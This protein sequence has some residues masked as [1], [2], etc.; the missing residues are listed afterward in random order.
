RADAWGATESCRVLVRAGWEWCIAPSTGERRIGR[1]R[2][3]RWR[4]SSTRPRR[5][6]AWSRRTRRDR[7][8]RGGRAVTAGS[9]AR[10]RSPRSTI[11]RASWSPP[12]R[13]RAEDCNTSSS[14]R[15]R[16]AWRGP[17]VRLCRRRVGGRGAASAAT[18]TTRSPRSGA[19]HFWQRKSPPPERDRE[20]EK[21]M[22]DFPDKQER[23]DKRERTD[24]LNR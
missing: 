22:K 3:R 7:C 14:A 11:A 18:R 8:R 2:W 9:R 19:S 4:P 23:I 20:D 1:N 17:A 5:Q 12:H 10:R 13:R 21:Y 16:W 6:A 24:K 15:R